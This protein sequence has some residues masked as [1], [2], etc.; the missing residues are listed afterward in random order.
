MTFFCVRLEIIPLNNSSEINNNNLNNNITDNLIG[1]IKNDI[2]FEKLTKMEK[3]YK[4]ENFIKFIDTIPKHRFILIPDCFNKNIKEKFDMYGGIY[5][6][7]ESNRKFEVRIL[8]YKFKHIALL[9]KEDIKKFELIFMQAYY[10]QNN[11]LDQRYHN[12]RQELFLKVLN[13]EK[14]YNLSYKENKC[15]RTKLYDYQRHNM[16]IIHSFESKPIELRFN[17]ETGNLIYNYENDITYDF[18]VNKFISKEDIPAHYIRGGLVMD[19]TG[20]GKTY[21]MILLATDNLE[22]KTLILIPDHIKDHWL[23]QFNIHIC[24]PLEDLTNI[25]IMTFSE[26]NQ[27][28]KNLEYD[29]IIIDEIH[30]LYKFHQN[31]FDKVIQI[32][33]KYRW[34]MSATPFVSSKSLFCLLKFFVGKNIVNERIINIPDIQD[35]FIKIFIKNTKENTKKELNLPPVEIKDI[36]VEMDHMQK[37]IYE[38]EKKTMN[39]TL[40]LRQLLCDIQLR[41]GSD[42]EQTM[43]PSQLKNIVLEKYKS[44]YET[45]VKE[46]EI[47]DEQV[48]KLIEFY[49]KAKKENKIFLDEIELKRRIHTFELSINKKKEEIIHYKNAYDYYIKNI[50]IIENLI[51]NESYNKDIVNQENEDDE[52]CPICMNLYDP[53]ISYFKKCGHFFCKSC[54]DHMKTLNSSNIKCPMCRTSHLKSD[55]N[56]INNVIDITSSSK[57]LEIIT[58]IKSTQKRFIVFTQFSKMIDNLNTIFTRNNINSMNYSRF[59]NSLD[60]DSVQIIILSSEENASGIDLSFISDVIIFEPFEDHYYCKEIEKQLIGRC[61]RI[62]QKNKVNVYRYICKETIEEEIYSKF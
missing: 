49:E 59:K 15:A 8:F 39:G 60:K 12:Y 46:K 17:N 19:E 51:K 3:I 16:S 50:N 32:K 9:T 48:K 53:P 26:F 14:I 34:G 37:T 23:S 47:L 61:D 40:S 27:I 6:I 54:I 55:I 36:F 1:K 30:E 20:L 13:K 44:D 45:K 10:I 35:E 43:T 56:I 41:F 25:D 31:I 33:A 57:S 11:I 38:S 5:N 21:Q 28:N 24:I 58:L 4:N 29:R 52:I 22:K 18:T 42:T 62:G 2:N 7:I